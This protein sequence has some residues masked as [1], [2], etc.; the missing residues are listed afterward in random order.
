MDNYNFDEKLKEGID[1]EKELD[2]IFNGEFDIK[3]VNMVDQRL[4]IDRRFTRKSNGASLTVEYKSDS[5]AAKTGN[6]FIETISVDTHN[7][8]GWAKTSQAD[9]LIYY[10]P[11]TKVIIV[12][13]M[14][15]VQ[16]SVARWEKVYPKKSIPNEGYNTIG[17]LVPL[18]ELT[19]MSI[20][21]FYTLNNVPT[22]NNILARDSLIRK[23]AQSHIAPGFS[24][25]KQGLL[26]A[27]YSI[28]TV[29]S[30][31]HLTIEQLKEMYSKTI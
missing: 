21:N 1:F 31:T 19:R 26:F 20:E 14:Q 28:K 4:G 27:E 18:I 11:P 10:I 25:H 2:E 23:I 5:K 6:A 15:A 12:L 13:K 3:P 22:I 8:T 29:E 30:W 17:V 24:L 9:I 7:K 16:S